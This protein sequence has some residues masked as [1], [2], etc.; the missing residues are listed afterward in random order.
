[1]NIKEEKITK[2]QDLIDIISNHIEEN[3]RVLWFRGQQDA[4]WSLVPSIWRHDDDDERN[5]VHRFRCRAYSRQKGLPGYNERAKW[6]SIMP[7]QG[8]PTRLLDWTR[9]PLIA[10]YF[11]L[12]RSLYGR[13]EPKSEPKNA[14]VWMLEPHKLNQTEQ[15]GHYTPSIESEQCLP[16]I[17]AA[18]DENPSNKSDKIF[19]VMSSE[20]DMRMFV[21]QGCFTIHARKEPLDKTA[22]CENYLTKFVLPQDVVKELSREIDCLGF[23]KGDLFPDLSNLADEL[24]N[25]NL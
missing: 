21:Q 19:A 20:V 7:H 8:L 14:C 23:R 3:K 22:G 5:F 18:F 13:S 17:D 11:A 12:E 2:I 25:R 15:F 6:L 10:M 4:E 1:M 9:S 16:L 24:S